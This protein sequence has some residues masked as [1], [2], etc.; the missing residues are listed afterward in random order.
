MNI[1]ELVILFF[2]LLQK[3]KHLQSKNFKKL[4]KL[5]CEYSFPMKGQQTE[6]ILFHKPFIALHRGEKKRK[7]I[8]DFDV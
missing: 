8:E 1:W 2:L 3:I 5:T 7:K 6:N 4:K